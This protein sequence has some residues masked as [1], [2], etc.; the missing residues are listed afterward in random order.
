MNME[1]QNVSRRKG[2]IDEIWDHFSETGIIEPAMVYELYGIWRNADKWGDSDSKKNAWALDRA[3]FD[4]HQD[5]L[6]SFRKWE[7]AK[8][9]LDGL[10]TPPLERLSHPKT[11]KIGSH[12]ANKKTKVNH[13]LTRNVVDNL[14]NL[15]GFQVSCV[16]SWCEECKTTRHSYLIITNN[17]LRCVYKK[18]L[19]KPRRT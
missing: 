8:E 1:N 7:E 2:R 10:G 11:S 5:P 14:K 12:V 9:S 4:V 17:V 16:W 6:M 15:S 18:D 3:M 13:E 19:I